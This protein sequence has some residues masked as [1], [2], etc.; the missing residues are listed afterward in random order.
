MKIAIFGVGIVATLLLFI[1]GIIF[2]SHRI[3]SIWIIFSAIVA[4]ALS[5]VLYWH[6][7]VITNPELKKPTF[8]ASVD[9]F[10]FSL[11]ERGMSTGYSRDALKVPKEP[12]NLGGYKPVKLYIKNGNLFADVHIFGGAGLPPIQIIQNELINKPNE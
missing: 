3:T 7:D 2:N 10:L 1:A 11:G 8:S 12:Y 9:K 4:Y 6:N 5:F